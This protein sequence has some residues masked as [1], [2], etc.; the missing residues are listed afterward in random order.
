MK[1][2]LFFVIATLALSNLM[3]GQ[4]PATPATPLAANTFHNEQRVTVLGYEGVL[5]EPF[6]SRDGRWLFFNNSNSDPVDTNLHYAERIDDL[7]FQ[8][9]GEIA[10]VNSDALDAVASMDAEGNFYFVSLRSYFETFSSLWRGRFVDGQV[11]DL[12][13][14]PGVSRKEP[15]IINFDAEISADGEWLVFDDGKFSN[16]NVPD[17]ADLVLARRRGGR[18]ERLPLSDRLLANVNTRDNLEYA[19]SLSPDGLTLFFTRLPADLS[20]PPVIMMAVRESLDVSFGEPEPVA[21][22]TGFVEAP[23]LSPD[24]RRLYYHKREGQGF[25]LYSVE[26]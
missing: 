26:R 8:Y 19:P 20:G 21:G 18:F 17:Q 4:T 11:T 24:G 9:R 22:I 5:M 15:G 2:R 7:T 25:V 13:L 23:T 6:I 10:G 1:K 3:C 14:V 16:R 12:E